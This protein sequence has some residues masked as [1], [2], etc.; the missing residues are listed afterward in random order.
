[1][2]IRMEGD[3]ITLGD[4]ETVVAN[5]PVGPSQSS[6]RS[7]RGPGDQ[8]VPVA[9]VAD[10]R[11]KLPAQRAREP[12]HQGGGRDYPGSGRHEVRRREFFGKLNIEALSAS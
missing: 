7:K 5:G 1:M 12:V 8:F 6:R 4:G 3:F 2:P 11:D 10:E 9:R